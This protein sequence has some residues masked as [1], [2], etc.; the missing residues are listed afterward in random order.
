M[1]VSGIQFP[2]GEMLGLLNAKGLQE[3]AV[4]DLLTGRVTDLQAN[5]QGVFRQA[6]GGAL[7]FSGAERLV[8]GEQVQ[9][10]VVRLSPVVTLQ[11]VA[12]DSRVAA[13]L[14]EMTEQ[15]LALGPE[16]F[17]RLLQAAGLEEGAA[18][19]SG[20]LASPQ[21][22]APDA[23][24]ADPSTRQAAEGSSA[25]PRG[26]ES[27]AS[28]L[29]RNLPTL[30]LETLARGEI[31][32]LAQLL[33]GRREGP[34][35]AEAVRD[36]RQAATT[37]HSAVEQGQ[38]ASADTS[39]LTSPG[40]PAVSHAL[41]RMGDMLAAQDL[42]PS[43]RGTVDVGALLGYR[44]FWVAEGGLGEVIWRQE[45]PR[46]RSQGAPDSRVSVLFC[47]SLTRLGLVHVH[48]V[49]G[50]GGLLLRF[51]AADP[52]TVAALRREVAELRTGLLTT[53]IPLQAV[54]FSHSTPAA[55][56]SARLEALGL[57]GEF[58]AEA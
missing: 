57:A 28:L 2:S 27:L 4:G 9:L 12:S 52:G 21:A 56:R 34:A 55:M 44:I 43:G 7:V 58:V 38:S 48:L 30:S 31:E 5:G 54:E 25:I 22:A 41:H 53:D 11:V 33:E 15:S 8:E 16:V 46:G 24:A 13:R 47:L 3:L 35:A 29:R 39:Q 50:T 36:L 40:R 42:L 51:A 17:A 19:E 45:H 6:N 26:E 23:P 32:E 18:S 37:W 1:I 10:R 14:A 49:S 20:S